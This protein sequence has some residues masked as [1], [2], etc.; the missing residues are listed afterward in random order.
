MSVRVRELRDQP[1]DAWEAYVARHPEGTIFHTLLWRDAV[2][3]AFGH[4]S[5]YLTAWR[6]NRLVGVFPLSRVRTYLAGTILVSVP[7]AVYGGALADDDE[8]RD[9][10]WEHAR[11]HADRMGAQWM[12]IRS[13]RPQRP[14]LPVL[15]RYVTFRKSL[16][17][18]P[19]RILADMP[20]KAR[21]AARHARERYGLE[22]SFDDAHLD[23]V[24]SLYSQSMRRI[25][26]L[27][28]PSCFFR[29]LMERTAPAAAAVSP[30]GLERPEAPDDQEAGPTCRHLVQLVLHR[31]RPVAGL[32]SFMFR[33][34]LMP[35]FA[36]CDERF[37]KYHPNNL[38]YLAA[39]EQGV[40]LGCR[41][42]DFGRS[43]VENV[44][45]CNFK[46][47]QGFEPTPL[48]YQYYVP[49]GGREPDLT[50]SHPR[51]ALARRVWPRLP[52]AVTRPLGAWLSKSIPG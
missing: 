38:M 42:F 29:A 34:M 47:F 31:G 14:G 19:A 44:G 20:R 8:A 33:D 9:A 13:I 1:S 41:L 11:R 43:R 6:D 26:S 22:V 2:T 39:M 25:A 10:L 36:G 23:T 27:N 40:A 35:Y 37:E 28:Y 46:R 52:L 12:D 51:V 16:P 17:D 15:T 18:D 5:R 45:A 21:A 4:D 7:Y 3:E 32:V 48:Y 24:W 50:P 49:R 30:V